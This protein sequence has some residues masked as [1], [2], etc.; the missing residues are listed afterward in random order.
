MW[1]DRTHLHARAE[2]AFERLGR[3]LT[4]HPWPVIVL[5]SA[6]GLGLAAQA[7]HLRIEMGLESFFHADDPTLLDYNDFRDQ[8]GRDELIVLAIEPPEIFDLE[9]LRKLVALHHELEDIDQVDEVTS[10]V[11]IR[12]TR[13]EGERLIVEDLLDELPTS[14][15]EMD[16]LRD[17]VLANPL[18]RDL[19]ISADGQVVTVSIETDV[20]TASPESDAL[21][22]FD[23]G[24]SGSGRPG[25]ITGEETAA[26]LDRVHEVV[27]RY[28]GPEFPVRFSGSVVITD[29]LV[30]RVG[31]D[32]PRFVGL[33]V[34]VIAVALYVLLRRLSAV[35]LPL[36]VILLAGAA[37]LG[38]MG[39]L[40]VPITIPMQ[41]LP[42]L[43]VSIGVGYAVHLLMA[44]Y[45][46]LDAGESRAGAVV[47]ALGQVG[48]PIA[49]TGVTTVVGLLGFLPA[50]LAPISSFG[51]FAP[52]GVG[53][54]LGLVLLLLPALLAVSP[55]RPRSGAARPLRSGTLVATG[56]W[57]T[58]HPGPVIAGAVVLAAVAGIGAARLQPVADPMLWL[59]PDDPY[60][61]GVEYID[62][63]MG[64]TLALEVV[65]DTGRPD[66][67]AD[68]ELLR[69]LDSLTRLTEAYDAAGDEMGRT[70]SIVDVV[71][72]THQALNEN[73]PELY[74]I[75]DDPALI[76][77]ELLLFENSGTDDL[78]DVTDARLQ[79]A[80]FTVRT[81][82][83]DSYRRR[84][85]LDRFEGELPR[86][87]GDGV[88]TRLT[89]MR[90]LISRASGAVVDSMATSYLIAFA[91]ITPLMILMIGEAR[92]GLISMVPNLL[93]IVLTLG[94]IGALS[95]PFDTFSLQIGCIA[96]SLAVDDTIHLIHAFRRLRAGGL[97]VEDAIAGALET[98]GTALLFTSI[99]LICGF[100]V[101]TASS[102]SNVVDFGWL[103]A[104]AIAAAFLCD[105]I[106]TPA[107]LALDGHV[108]AT[109][110]PPVSVSGTA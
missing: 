78:E 3:L 10:L 109:R 92:A 72:E 48:L 76:R 28:Q 8:F 90:Q 104:F 6:L 22:G 80:R 51:V 15:A 89:G 63:R 108:R 49:M 61:E 110:R 99:V 107:L 62:E 9:F 24:P 67:I 23:A 70:I 83:T 94:V 85:V 91:L 36:L 96:I 86:I 65:V 11:D 81:P 14:T 32:M 95:V 44:F 98:T 34:L 5:L 41:I 4:R 1:L 40:D 82:W 58:R 54:S 16:R 52:V 46:R 29:V 102:M 77:Q 12:A 35:V 39:A 42:S 56:R 64:G 57:A 69:R 43:L 30:R 75:P 105:V 37:T 53:L 19:V 84:E 103:T 27:E 60:R 38:L 33:S 7:R 21:A 45:R 66:G 68:P 71:K 106:I 17:Y 59:P 50:E 31:T 13:G 25:Y 79:L 101:F 88:E 26:I 93:P 55:I 87:L 2:S 100:G 20:F 47:G 73:R 74:A 18:Y 97:D